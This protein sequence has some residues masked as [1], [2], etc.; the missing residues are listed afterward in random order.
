MS[1][2]SLDKIDAIIKGG[3]VVSPRGIKRVDIAISG[4]KIKEI[5][6]DLGYE[7]DRL[8]DASAKLVLPGILDIHV[9]PVYVDDI[10]HLSRVAAYGGVTTLMH[11]IYIN[12]GHDVAGTLEGAIADGNRRSLLDFGLHVGFL[13]PNNQWHFVPEAVKLGV[14]S[15][16]VFMSYAKL[17]QMISDYNLIAAMDLIA[18]HGGLILV[19]AESGLAIDYLED[20]LMAQGEQGPHSL[21]VSHPAILETEAVYRASCFAAAVNCPLYIP[22]VAAG[23]AVEVIADIKATGQRIWAETCPH[24]LCLTEKAVDRWGTLAKIGPPLR[25]EADS[26]SLWDG[27]RDGILDVVASDHAPKIKDPRGDL[28]KASFGSPGTETL[29]TMMY[30]EG[31]NKGRITLSRLVELLSETPAKIFG[32]YPA[33]GALEVGSDA[34]LVIVD[35]AIEW[36]ITKEELHSKANYSLFEGWRCLGRPIFSMQRGR[37][38]LENG[39]LKAEV[40]QGRFLPV[41]E[42]PLVY[43]AR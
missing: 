13:D 7:A 24:Y 11:F 15:F 9:H 35:P 38:L 1:T 43:G 37:I 29:L 22:H 8:I 28:W 6:I 41:K 2:G 23:E 27:L 36:T 18:Q 12:A 30:Q 25:S 40:G 14:R 3:L 17:G 26:E 34:D 5:G 19:H 4:G 20:K 16:K 39:E 42:L 33:K 10:E 31:Y 32:L 21:V